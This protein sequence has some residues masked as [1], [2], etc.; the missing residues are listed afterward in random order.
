MEQR[1][2]EIIDFIKE[3]ERVSAKEILVG[4]PNFAM[5]SATLKRILAK[6]IAQQYIATIGQG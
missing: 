3:R 5:S 4:T 1:E 2:Q 6:L